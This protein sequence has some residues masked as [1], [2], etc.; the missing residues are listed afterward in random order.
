MPSNPR[1]L[2]V[3]QDPQSRAEL[4]QLLLKSRFVVVGGVGYD[5]EAVGLAGEQIGRASC[6]E[7]V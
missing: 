6:R 7:R 3:D 2:L 1:I 5:E 4:Q